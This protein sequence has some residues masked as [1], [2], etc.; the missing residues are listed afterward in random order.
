MFAVTESMCRQYYL[1][2]IN[3]LASS[4]S[5]ER[6]FYFVSGKLEITQNLSVYNRIG[7]DFVDI[8]QFSGTRRLAIV[9]WQI[10]PLISHRL[11]LIRDV[12]YAPSYEHGRV[13]FST[14]D[15]GKIIAIASI[16]KREIQLSDAIRHLRI[17]VV[18]ALVE[19]LVTIAM[20]NREIIV[21]GQI[22][23]RFAGRNVVAMVVVATAHIHLHLTAQIVVIGRCIAGAAPFCTCR[24]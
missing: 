18:Q 10:E 3:R 21:V 15:D 7:I 8:V 22:V 23:F 19:F 12:T 24:R 17:D 6:I 5:F 4:L 13:I 2:Q 16:S 9:Q 1:L 20:Q 14:I 11:R